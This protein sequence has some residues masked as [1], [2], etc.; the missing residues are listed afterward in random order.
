[1]SPTHQR[2]RHEEAFKF[3]EEID[4]IHVGA[5]ASQ[6]WNR[7]FY[8]CRLALEDPALFNRALLLMR[9]APDEL[10]QLL[11]GEP[12]NVLSLFF[13]FI[14]YVSR[15]LQGLTDRAEKKQFSIVVRALIR[16]AASILAPGTSSSSSSSVIEGGGGSSHRRSVRH[17][18]G[19]MLRTLVRVDDDQLH[20]L[21][22]KAWKMSC[23]TWDEIVSATLST[24][25]NTGEGGDAA[26]Q[27]LRARIGPS[28]TLGDW[29]NFQLIAPES[30]SSVEIE[31]KINSKLTGMH[32]AYGG[33]II[34]QGVLGGWLDLMTG[35]AESESESSS[36]ESEANIKGGAYAVQQFFGEEISQL[37][38]LIWSTAVTNGEAARIHEL[39]SRP[40]QDGTEERQVRAIMEDSMYRK[41]K[42]IAFRKNVPPFVMFKSVTEAKQ[43]FRRLGDGEEFWAAHGDFER[44]EAVGTWV[45]ELMGDLW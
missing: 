36:A 14:V 1:M 30:E 10:R 26:E 24:L 19:M 29:L 16:Y 39:M 43:A 37:A 35:A 32:Q 20:P 41:Y 3:V 8:R 25:Q 13:K 11:A 28:S 4:T 7:F 15:C 21:A 27:Q 18:L 33:E 45:G 12:P 42:N 9:Q 40:V 5:P 23:Q 31:A 17:P 44:A 6:Q 2:G 34:R 38:S 22:L